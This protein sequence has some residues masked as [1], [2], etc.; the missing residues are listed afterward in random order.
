M[1]TQQHGGVME[2]TH[3]QMGSNCWK[4]P[5]HISGT[6]SLPTTNISRMDEQRQHRLEQARL[7]SGSEEDRS[8]GLRELAQRQQQQRSNETT[9]QHDAS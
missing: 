9:H 8:A 7:Q 2:A 6:F 5:L 4:E 3:R 1:R